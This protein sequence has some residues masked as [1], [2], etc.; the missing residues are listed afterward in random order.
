M[1]TMKQIAQL[2]GVSRGTVDRVLNKRGFVNE[3]TAKK[4]IDIANSLHYT[5]SKAARSL[6]TLKRNLKLTYIMP[7]PK[8][9]H[10]FEQVRDGVLKKAADLQEYGVT[11]E[12]LYSDFSAP[13]TQ[14]HQLDRA[15]SNGTSGIAIAGFNNPE[16]ADKLREISSSGIPIVT[17][18]TDIANCGR[19]AYVGSDSYKCGETA[20]GMVRMITHGQAKVGIINGSRNIMCHTERV[21]GFTANL[22]KYAPNI[23]IIKTVENLD[24]DFE[25]FSVTKDLLLE[26]PEIDT[27]FVTG[28]GVY[29]ACRA[30]ESLRLAVL[31]HIICYDCTH[32]TREMMEKN[33]ILVSICQQPDIQGSKPLDIL[34]NS[35]A[36]GIPPEEEY[37]HTKIE[38]VIRECL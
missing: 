8:A 21:S 25:S 33:V 19:I 18:N 2:A 4:V 15:V 26:H 30:V 28:A 16:A 32:Q 36:L 13:E 12:L 27:L 6:A 24:E 37:N 5:P 34:F 3:A 1:A 35:V 11:V 10:F 7:D 14:N 31:P 22:K 9:N 23:Q 29:G 20:A 38:I 17:V